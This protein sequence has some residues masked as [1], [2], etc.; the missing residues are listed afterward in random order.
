MT[1]LTEGGIGSEVLSF[2]P[3]ESASVSD[4]GRG[5]IRLNLTLGCYQISINGGPWT[6][7]NYE[8]QLGGAASGSNTEFDDTV[9]STSLGTYVNA[10]TVGIS[11]PVDGDYYI[12]FE[13][14]LTPN[15]A[16]AVGQIALGINSTTVANA[17]SQRL[18]AGTANQPQT[19]VSTNILTGLVVSDVIYGIFRKFTGPGAVALGRR[20]VTMIR[21]TS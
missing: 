17:D 13:G 3:G 20:R 8:G 10:F 12:I 5:R 2:D 9:I 21:V 16:N 19:V 4:S 6:C 14:V 18:N 1:I 11:P 7:I 15:N